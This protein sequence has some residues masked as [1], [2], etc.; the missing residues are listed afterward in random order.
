M[1]LDWLLHSLSAPEGNSDGSAWL[2]RNGIRLDI[3]PQI[4]L[5][6][7]LTVSDR[8]GVDVNAG[9]AEQYHVSPPKQYHMTW[10]TQT[11]QQHRIQVV[12]KITRL[13]ETGGTQL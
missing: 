2:V 6:P 10:K 3:L 4:G 12:L 1:E 8:F 13:S 7:G 5:E 11:K 9:Q